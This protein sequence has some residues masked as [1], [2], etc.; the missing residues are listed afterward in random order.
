MLS[1]IIRA[2]EIDCFPHFFL[3][4]NSKYN[5]ITIAIKGIARKAILNE[6][7]AWIVQVG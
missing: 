3:V 5:I 7:L 6:L 2:F 4:L 1:R